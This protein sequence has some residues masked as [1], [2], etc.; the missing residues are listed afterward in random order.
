MLFSNKIKSLIRNVSRSKAIKSLSKKKDFVI[1][2]KKNI[3]INNFKMGT[4][5]F[6]NYSLNENDIDD[7]R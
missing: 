2:T 5:I 6:I 4:L 7:D 1:T 3:I